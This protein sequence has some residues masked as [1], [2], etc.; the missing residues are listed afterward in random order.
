MG[1]ALLLFAFFCGFNI[2]EASLP[3]IVSRT[4]DASSKGLALGV[5][6]T[7]QSLGLFAGGALGGWLSESWGHE[8]VFLFCLASLLV[9]VLTASG[10]KVPETHRTGEAVNI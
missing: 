4:A 6:N 7:T 8:A 5:Y 3:S 10:M 9:W 2:L 1:F